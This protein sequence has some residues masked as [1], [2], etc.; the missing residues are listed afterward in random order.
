[1]GAARRGNATRWFHSRRSRQN[2]GRQLHAHLPHGGRLS[3]QR[4]PWGAQDHLGSSKSVR[5]SLI[6]GMDVSGLSTYRSVPIPRLVHRSKCHTYSITFVGSRSPSSCA[7]RAVEKTSAAAPRRRNVTLP[8]SRLWLRFG[9]KRFILDGPCAREH[10]AG[11]SG[12]DSSGWQP[13]PRRAQF[14]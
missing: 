2:R 12:R 5:F 13:T 8:C 11:R 9:L 1:M 14:A 10:P 6:P 4:K 3:T 7:G